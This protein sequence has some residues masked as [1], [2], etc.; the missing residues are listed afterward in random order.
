VRCVLRTHSRARIERWR[1]SCCEHT[2]STRGGNKGAR[3][4]RAL[5][6]IYGHEVLE[7]GTDR[8]FARLRLAPCTPVV[9]TGLP[10]Y[11]RHGRSGDR[12]WRAITSMRGMASHEENGLH[13]VVMLCCPSSAHK[14]G[15][16]RVR[17]D[18]KGDTNTGCM[19]CRQRRR[20]QGRTQVHVVGLH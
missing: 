1:Y 9:R 18:N 20:R 14:Q 17:R 10:V 13:M 3:A 15:I 2:R 19:C 8:W 6:R 5:K 12:R 4:S 7:S 16:E 11:E